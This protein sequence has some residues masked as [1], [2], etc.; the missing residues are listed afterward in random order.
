MYVYE[1]ADSSYAYMKRKHCHAFTHTHAYQQHCHHHYI[2]RVL[3]TAA[4]V[5]TTAER[6]QRQYL[7]LATSKARKLRVPVPAPPLLAPHIP[8]TLPTQHP[9]CQNL[10]FCPSKPMIF[11][12]TSKASIPLLCPPQHQAPPSYTPQPA[13]P[14]STRAAL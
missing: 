13:L 12:L 14:V 9:R 7:H 8:L 11:F 3:L 2:P 4:R 1:E 5:P 6:L 10:Y